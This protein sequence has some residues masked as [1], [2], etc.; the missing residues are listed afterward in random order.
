VGHSFEICPTPLTSAQS[1]NLPNNCKGSPGIGTPVLKPGDAG[2]L[3]Y[4]FTTPGTYEYLSAA[5]GPDSGDATAG[6]KG[7]LTV[8]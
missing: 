4:D 6:M 8:A 2:S 1:Q 7:Q 3:S 5:R